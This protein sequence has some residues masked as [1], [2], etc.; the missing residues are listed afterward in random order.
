MIR[1]PI[2]SGMQAFPPVE[3]ALVEPNGLLAAGG[4]LS[5]P[6]LLDAYARGIFPWFSAGEP[7]LW[8]SPDPR[9]VFDAGA[10]HAPRR[11]R[12]WLRDCRWTLSADRD[13]EAVVRAC[14]APRAG[15][16]GTWITRAMLDAYLRLHDLGHAHSVEVWDGDDLVGGIYGVARGRMFFG[17]SMFSRRDHASKVALLGLADALA[18]CGFPLLDAQ[19][20]SAH[21]ATLGAFELARSDFLARIATLVDAAGRVGSWSEGFVVGEAKCLAGA[22]DASASRDGAAAPSPTSCG[23]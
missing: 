5:V 11:L 19:V 4:D 12:R 15:Q 17:E 20:S 3:S 10:M 13:F 6:R 9:M 22:G 8:W 21:L 7:I 14:A 1:I 2:L 16:S 23:R 18:R